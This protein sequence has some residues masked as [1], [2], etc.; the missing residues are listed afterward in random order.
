M[1]GGR[2][3]N[4]S[5]YT[6]ACVEICKG[7]TVLAPNIIPLERSYQYKKKA[8]YKKLKNPEISSKNEDLLQICKQNMW[9]KKRRRRCCRRCT[10]FLSIFFFS[11]QIPENS[12][13]LQPRI[14]RKNV[15]L[16]KYTGRNG[17]NYGELNL[18]NFAKALIGPRKK[19]F[20]CRVN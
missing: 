7:A 18:E 10:F 20:F 5:T 2:R 12:L 14:A 4:I 1:Y 6:C 17:E 3:G 8:F 9:Y 16:P 15:L 19:L 11:N 13:D